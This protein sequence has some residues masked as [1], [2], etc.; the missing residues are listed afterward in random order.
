MKKI[1]CGNKVL[2]ISGK[3]KGMIG[4][5]KKIKKYLLYINNINN[6]KKNIKADYKMKKSGYII[7]KESPI[8]ISNVSIINYITN[9]PDKIGIKI[10]ANKYKVK[11]FKSNGKIINE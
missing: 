10:N 2:V 9:K 1:N 5:V 6:I 3:C 4:I 7:M 11:F 8:H